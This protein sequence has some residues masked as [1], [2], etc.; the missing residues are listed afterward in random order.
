MVHE[1]WIQLSVVSKVIEHMKEGLAIAIKE[2]LTGIVFF[3]FDDALEPLLQKRSFNWAE[4]SPISL[5][6]VSST[7]IKLDDFTFHIDLS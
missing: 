7:N 2:D 4:C 1:V 3:E 6:V 5:Q